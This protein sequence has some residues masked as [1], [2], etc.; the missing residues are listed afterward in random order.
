MMKWCCS[1]KKKGPS[2][3]ISECNQNIVLLIQILHELTT[4][5][6]II[7]KLCTHLYLDL[8]RLKNRCVCVYKKE[9]KSPPALVTLVLET[10]LKE[11][12]ICIVN[13]LFYILQDLIMV[14]EKDMAGTSRTKKYFLPSWLHESLIITL[15]RLL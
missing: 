7:H 3:L 4:Y 15:L 2:C 8:N 11:K 13:L 9:L 5:S 14:E 1:E 6:G 12:C 10:E